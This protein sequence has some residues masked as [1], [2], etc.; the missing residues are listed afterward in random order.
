[1]LIKNKNI[2]ITGLIPFHILIIFISI[3]VIL[4]YFTGCASAKKYT[5]DFPDYNGYVNDYTDTLSAEWKTKTENL[6]QA[7]REETSCEIAVAVIDELGGA[8][9][10]EYA[11]GLFAKWGIGK[12]DKDNG[13]LL[14]VALKDKQLRI[15]VGYGLEAIIPDLRAKDIIDDVI[16]PRFKNSDYDSGVYNGVVAIANI[17][18]EE[19]DKNLLPYSDNFINQPKREF[20]D[21]PAFAA[22]IILATLLPWIVFA[23]IFLISFLRSYIKKHRCPRCKKIALVIKTKILSS[24]TYES[25]GRAHVEK[26]CRKC[27]YAEKS[28]I[29]LPILK[30]SS[31]SGSGSY[32]SSFS[33]G[34]SSSGSS[35]SSSSFGGGSSGGGGAS[36][37]W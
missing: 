30:K 2:R 16:T 18:Y 31:Y 7:V 28:T 27:G 23:L 5:L 20:S 15:E 37:R 22:L 11:A 35:G 13:V 34:S 6:A 25:S 10:E 21:T 29:T 1:M 36:G 17:I 4:I 26:F 32:G 12:K 33:S 19:Q 9:I 24:P 8:T 3:L 14:L